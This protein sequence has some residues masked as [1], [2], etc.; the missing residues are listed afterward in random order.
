MKRMKAI[1]GLLL[2]ILSITAMLFWETQGREILLYEEVIAAQ[3]DIPA[4]TRILEEMIGTMPVLEENRI[5]GSFGPNQRQQIVGQVT[6]QLIL[7]DTQISSRYFSKAGL[8]L[9]QDES[10]FV[11]EPQ[12]V[13]MRSSSLRRGDRIHIYTANGKELVGSYQVAFVKDNAEREVK[14]IDTNSENSPLERQDGTSVISRIE[15]ITTLDGYCR[16]LDTVHGQT[17]SALMIVQGG[18]VSE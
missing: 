17:P 14:S 3:T 11:I 8:M 13:S 1:V 6:R 18:F 12:W 5:E 10:V 7:K 2:I 16:I 9:K 15:V 4:G